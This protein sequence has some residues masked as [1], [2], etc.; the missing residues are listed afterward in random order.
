MSNLHNR[1]KH[2]EKRRAPIPGRERVF[3]MPKVDYR[4][5]IAPDV[6]AAP[7]AIPVQIV[8][9]RQNGEGM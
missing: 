7:D 8:D 2:L 5:D 3:V 1:V 6:K 4:A 9:V